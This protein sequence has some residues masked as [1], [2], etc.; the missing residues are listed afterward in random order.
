MFAASYG[1]VPITETLLR[2]GAN[3]NVVP[4]DNEGKTALMAAASK[5]HKEVVELLLQYNAD[6]NLRNKKSQT[7]LSYAEGDT[8]QLLIAAGGTL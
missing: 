7:A 6:P 2:N 4:N 5:G 3:P 8:K 1:S